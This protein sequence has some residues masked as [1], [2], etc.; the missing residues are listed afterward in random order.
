MHTMQD[1]TKQIFIDDRFESYGG[2]LRD[3]WAQQ[4]FAETHGVMHLE[5]I[6]MD[7]T[8]S[9]RGAAYTAS[10]PTEMLKHFQVF[11]DAY[12]SDPESG[13][14]TARLADAVLLRLLEDLPQLVGEHQL[15]TRLH[16]RVSVLTKK[17]K[18]AREKAKLILSIDEIWKAYLEHHVFKLTLW[19]SLRIC[20]VAIYGAYDDFVQRCTAIASGNERIRTTQQREFKA[21]FIGAFGEQAY[22]QCWTSAEITLARHVRNSLAHAAGRVPRT[23]ARKPHHFRVDDNVIQVVPEDIKWLFAILGRA[24]LLIAASAREHPAFST[25]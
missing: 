11:V 24:T 1:V 17:M 8:A 22:M 20:F 3:E 19:S 10:F 7:L 2:L 21:A 25:S 23:L 18:D 9:W 16:Q 6:A 4:F 13:A 14:G 5:Q 15:Q 12:T